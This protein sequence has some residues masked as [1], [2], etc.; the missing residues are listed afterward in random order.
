MLTITPKPAPLFVIDMVKAGKKGVQ[1]G[2]SKR[3]YLFR[4]PLPPGSA[5]PYKYVYP[6]DAA[7]FGKM[8]D[9]RFVFDPGKS[10]TK[11]INHIMLGGP[12]GQVNKHTGKPIMDD[13]LL[14]TYEVVHK[15]HY[16]NITKYSVTTDEAHHGVT[17][18]YGPNP[19]TTNKD[20]S[21]KDVL[22]RTTIGDYYVFAYPKTPVLTRDKDG[23]PLR[24]AGF[25]G[26]E[27]HPELLKDQY[28]DTSKLR[29]DIREHLVGPADTMPVPPVPPGL[30]PD[31][32]I[33]PADHAEM[34]KLTATPLAGDTTIT[35]LHQPERTKE[36]IE[37]LAGVKITDDTDPV[38]L[39]TALLKRIVYGKKAKTPEAGAVKVGEFPEW[40]R[41]KFNSDQEMIDHLQAM[42][43]TFFVTIGVMKPT[44]HTKKI[45]AKLLDE[46]A[47]R[48]YRMCRHDADAAKFTANYD[49]WR[50]KDEANG[51]DSTHPESM[52][53]QQMIK[54]TSDLAS[55][56]RE[57]FTKLSY[58]YEATHDPR[59]RFDRFASVAV[60]NHVKTLSKRWAEQGHTHVP[61]INETDIEDAANKQRQSA[62]LSPKD[63]YE[64]QRVT[65]LARHALARIF[66]PN[67]MPE[68]YARII[69]ARLFLDDLDFEQSQIAARG[70][71]RDA[72]AAN[73]AM[74]GKEL[75]RFKRDVGDWRRKWT[76]K[77]SI[78]SR[79]PVWKDPETGADVDL[80]QMNS[81]MQ[82]NRLDKWFREAMD[83]VHDQLSVPLKRTDPAGKVRKPEHDPQSRHHMPDAEWQTGRIF[84]DKPLDQMDWAEKIVTVAGVGSRPKRALVLTNEGRA[85]MR[86]LELESKLAD[87]ARRR[88]TEAGIPQEEDKTLVPV[89][90]PVPGG[91]VGPLK[92][93]VVIPPHEL[94]ANPSGAHYSSSPAITFFSA[95]KNQLLAQRLGLQLH[96]IANP[97]GGASHAMG[98]KPGQLTTPTSTGVY[99]LPNVSLGTFAQRELSVAQGHYDKL[100]A[101]RKLSYDAIK[102]EHATLAA[103]A[104]T[105]DALPVTALHNAAL[106]YQT[107]ARRHREMAAQRAARRAELDTVALT[108]D[109][110]KKKLKPFTPTEADKQKLVTR[111]AK[112]ESVLAQVHA[113]APA[114][115]DVYRADV[116]SGPSWEIEHEDGEET[117]RIDRAVI[118]KT[119]QASAESIVH[120]TRAALRH[121]TELLNFEIQR[122][123]DLKM[124][125]SLIPSGAL[126]K[127]FAMYDFALG[128]LFAEL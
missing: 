113:A 15:K 116:T 96:R 100:M 57:L 90:R 102:K 114:V 75:A 21:K 41:A 112:Y 122:R 125:K 104:K 9:G 27:L 42:P 98:A 81:D 55:H 53:R 86:Y 69:Q 35:T 4:I 127:A 63:A 64:L 40:V 56:A 76:G 119:H 93:V 45:N 18:H 50:A 62:P 22:E 83:Y 99:A 89:A 68:T 66:D 72:I 5:K 124:D 58:D 101:Y 31:L 92:H 128:R 24:Y 49:M 25:A 60:A 121:R 2:A 32:A 33:S 123:K 88:W 44:P 48:L 34:G 115:A 37:A 16:Q 108:K 117:R 12:S 20:G 84:A 65:P 77:D 67:K 13:G 11:L 14:R 79:Y 95:S 78:A 71:E 70:A 110:V 107:E 54:V 91:K 85:V 80:S 43:A 111:Q 73:T 30:S 38:A 6:E 103:A 82:Y 46:W 10:L 52:V 97:V 1:W 19:F 120:R 7:D 109:E 106:A 51:I 59:H 118:G 74:E 8:Q 47:P 28:V 29:A 3:T 36:E 87:T 94:P 26:I 61:I 39:K 23:K 17:T 105:L 126:Y